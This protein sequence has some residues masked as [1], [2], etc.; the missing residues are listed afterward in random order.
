MAVP[1]AT[2]EKFPQSIARG[3]ELIRRR[4]GRARLHLADLR[5]QARLEGAALRVAVYTAALREAA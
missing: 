2:A 3:S 1:A 5:D 4:A